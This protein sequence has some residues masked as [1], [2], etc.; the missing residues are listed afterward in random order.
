MIFSLSNDGIRQFQFSLSLSLS[1]S[2]RRIYIRVVFETREFTHPFPVIRR[3]LS[4]TT[5]LWKDDGIAGMD[6]D[7][8]WNTG[9]AGIHTTRAT[10]TNNTRIVWIPFGPTVRGRIRQCEIPGGFSPPVAKTNFDNNDGRGKII[11]R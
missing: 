11:T 2:L 4:C 10:R 9:P 3:S 8:A 1:V 7:G 5:N 6:R